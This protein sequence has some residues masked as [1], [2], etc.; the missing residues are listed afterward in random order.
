MIFVKN[1]ELLI[2]VHSIFNYEG[3]GDESTQAYIYNSLRLVTVSSG[4]DVIL[5]R[6]GC[7]NNKWFKK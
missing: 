3:R 5:E 6:I 7:L 4:L 2:I 1:Y